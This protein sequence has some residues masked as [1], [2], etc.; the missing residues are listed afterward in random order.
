MARKLAIEAGMKALE[1]ARAGQALNWSAPMTVSRMKPLDLPPAAVKAI[2]R[3]ATAKLPAYVGAETAEGYRVYRINR[4]T[5]GQAQPEMTKRIRN[6]IRRLV[7]QEEMRAYL[8]SIKARA[9]IKIQPSAL[10]P[11]AE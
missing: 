5:A 6:D 7:A 8:E 4:V 9:S 11:K 10:E 1:H 3:A 2:F